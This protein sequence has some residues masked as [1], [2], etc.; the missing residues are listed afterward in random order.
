[1]DD[2]TISRP[3]NA[4]GHCAME[5]KLSELNAYFEEQILRCGKRREQ[6]LAD[7][8]PD[9]ASLEKVRANVFDIFRTI[10]SVAVKLGKGEPEAVYSFF[11]EKTEQIPASWVLAYEKAA[12]HQNAADMLIEQIKLDTVGDIRKTFEKAWEEA[13]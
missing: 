1:M 10:L 3:E 8:R 7:D 4:G 13:V 9:E 11:L 6:L 2:K 5:Q 12:E